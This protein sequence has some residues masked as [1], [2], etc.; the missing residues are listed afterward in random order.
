MNLSGC[1][2]SACPNKWPHY[3]GPG[4]PG[5]WPM[6]SA[7]AHAPVL[8]PGSD[9]TIRAPYPQAPGLGA[10]G[11]VWGWHADH[12]PTW[13]WDRQPQVLLPAARTRPWWA[14]EEF[15][16][17]YHRAL[18]EAPEGRWDEELARFPRDVAALAR[19]LIDLAVGRRFARMMVDLQAVVSDWREVRDAWLRVPSPD[20]GIGAYNAEAFRLRALAIYDRLAEVYRVLP[21]I[22]LS[23]DGGLAGPRGMGIAPAAIAA[24]F[25]SAAGAILALLG[26]LSLYAWISTQRTQ[27][28]ANA[29]L[30]QAANAVCVA[31]PGSAACQQALDAAN[32][33]VPPPAGGPSDL[34]GQVAKIVAWGAVALLGFKAIEFLTTRQAVRRTATD[35]ALMSAS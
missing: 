8:W 3:A 33:G 6:E 1:T 25:L 34:L 10:P 23:Q 18:G 19:E 14:P 13:G 31:Q 11:A 35:R 22:G 16:A 17:P 20:A 26:G 21:D 24:I 15:V 2:A 5:Y 27:A 29:Q 30:A 4:C 28:Q 9:P 32:R 7:Y 12:H